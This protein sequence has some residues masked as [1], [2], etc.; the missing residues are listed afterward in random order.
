MR[1][2]LAA[3]IGMVGQVSEIRQA[4]RSLSRTPW[5]SVTVVSVIG[6]SMALL[7]TVFAVVDGVLFK[8]LPY[9]DASEVFLVTGTGAALSMQETRDWAAAVPAVQMAAYQRFFDI[10]SVGSPRPSVIRGAAVG[11][12][13]FEVLGV[14]PLFGAFSAADFEYSTSRLPLLISYGLWQ[15]QFGGRADVIGQHFVIAGAVNHLRRPLPAGEVVGV[16]AR[17]FVYRLSSGVPDVLIPSRSR[18]AGNAKSTTVQPRWSSACR[19]GC[20]SRRSRIDSLRSTQR[21]RCRPEYARAV[22]SHYAALRGGSPAGFLPRRLAECVRRRHRADAA[23]VRQRRGT[24]NGS[25]APSHTRIRGAAS[26]WRQRLAPGAA[27]G[28]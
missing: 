26:A 12:N 10:G 15:R 24:R 9:R 22:D 1:Q 23:R 16:L 21:F 17:D 7:A 8:R 27:H 4:I 6:L 25:P 5:Y 13:F 19:S 2:F 18:L 14:R 28:R 20:H 3:G 11:P